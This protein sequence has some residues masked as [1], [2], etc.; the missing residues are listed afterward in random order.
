MPQDAARPT[1]DSPRWPR[2][3]REVVAEAL[4]DR[5]YGEDVALRS[6]VLGVVADLVVAG[7]LAIVEVDR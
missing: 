5:G 2:P 7:Y 1:H 3:V 6:V 4:A